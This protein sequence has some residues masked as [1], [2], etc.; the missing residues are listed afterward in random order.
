MKNTIHDYNHKFKKQKEKLLGSSIS[1]KN[2]D[3]ILKFDQTCSLENL[4]LSRRM[5]LIGSLTILAEQYLKKDFDDVT[6]DDLKDTVVRIDAIENY[7]VWTKQSYRAIL[8]KFYKWLKYGDDY[9][10]TREYPKIVSWITTNIKSKDKPR[11][12]ASQILS[13]KEIKK[14]IDVAEHPRDKAFIT[15]LY[16][17][18]ARIG[19]LGNLR[20]GDVSRDKHSFI[21][22]LRGKT[23]HRAPR[24]VMSDPYLTTWLNQH[25]L[26]DNPDAPLWVLIGNQNRNHDMM[27]YQALRAT[28]LRLKDKAKLKK[29]IY[30]HLFRHSRVTHLLM[31]KEINESQ[32]K[33][34]FG[35]TPS[36]KM[37]SEYSHLVSS[38][39]NELILEINGIKSKEEKE[40]GLK[41]KPCP[42]CNKINSKEASFCQQCGKVLDVKTAIA[43]D[44]K[45]Q[46]YDNTLKQIL[47]GII[48][49]NPDS[50]LETVREL[51]LMDKLKGL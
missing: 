7:S 21:I 32:A 3:L 39:I 43:L 42:S 44:Q 38:D 37:L 9:K 30:P 28:V 26:K 49:K 5:K 2:K 12:Q 45:K 25:P 35:W 47:K 15:M 27:E 18:G 10:S 29:R 40:S 51:D 19:E 1:K 31:N 6:K 20:I 14:L 48:D 34:Y 22:D 50:V 16:E 23:G 24:I 33:V 36:S 46:N 17:L 4:S 41:P 13:E 8:K 11:V